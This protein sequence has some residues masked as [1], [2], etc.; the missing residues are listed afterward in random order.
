MI[1]PLLILSISFV[2]LCIADE[3]IHK[4]S[5]LQFKGTNHEVL[6]RTVLHLINKERVKK[7]V[8]TLGFNAALFQ[9]CRFYQSKLEFKSFSNPKAIE[10]KINKKINAKAKSN[11]YNGGITNSIAVQHNAIHY[12]KDKPFFYIKD[13]KNSEFGLYYGLKKDFKKHP[14]KVSEIPHFTYREFAQKLLN[15][16]DK[17]QRKI[18]YANSYKDIGIQLNWHYKSLHKKKIPQIKMVVVLGGY[19]TDGVR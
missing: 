11:G 3:T 15:S 8:D 17:R 13:D 18:L 4:D 14:E 16:L 6:N 7:E 1:K 5:V 19:M 2:S 12:E 10:S 9:L